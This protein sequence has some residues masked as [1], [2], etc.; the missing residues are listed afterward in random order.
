MQ[1]DMSRRAFLGVSLAGAAV[2]LA[3]CSK[4]GSPS[5]SGSKSSNTDGLVIGMQAA[6]T[7]LTPFATQGYNWSQMLGLAFYDTLVSK[8]AAGKLVP[9][10]ATAWDTTD[11]KVTVLTIRHGVHFHDGT[12]M[13]AKDVAYS[14]AARSDPAV[15]K[16]TSGRPVM[17]PDQFGSIEVVDDYTVRVHTKSRVEFMLDPQPVLIVPANSFGKVNYADQV[18]GTGPFKLKSFTS[19]SRVDTVAN[20]DYWG[21]KPQLSQL[22]FVLFS[23]VATEGVNLRSG[24]VDGLYDVAPLYLNQVQNVPGKTVVTA[25]TYMDWWIPQMGKG[26][27]A[28]VQVRKALRYC[29][30][31]E[32]LNAVS[33]KGMGKSTWNPFTLTKQSSGY[34]ATDVTYDPA[35]AKSLLAAAGASNISVP[36]IAIQGYADCAAQA[37]VIQ[38]GFK[39]AGIQCEIQTL[40]AS[41]WL[42]ATY[43]KGTWEGLA[44]NAGNLPS[45]SK[46]LF[47]YMVHPDCTLSAYTS[48]KPPVPAANDLYNKVEAAPFDSSEETALLAQAEKMLVD[49]CLTYFMFGGPVSLVLPKNLAGVDLNGYGDVRWNKAAFQ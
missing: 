29:F 42:D 24:Q 23:D 12:A 47:D 28:D 37:Q 18:N 38:Q 34:D 21:G 48:P 8:D 39:A 3:A 4:S 15:I 14:I 30:N 32:Q 22:A 10:I 44:F 26:P 7:S 6:I 41:A 11:P 13:T 25:A 9:G 36:L 17:S 27:L 19:G 45:P 20:P 16:Q 31:R 43:N 5:G 35:K 2:G 1:S 33:F 40:A 46:N 49:E